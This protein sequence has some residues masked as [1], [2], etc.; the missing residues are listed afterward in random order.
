MQV[1]L[2]E[3][4]CTALR[5]P[6]SLAHL[7]GEQCFLPRRQSLSATKEQQQRQVPLGY[8]PRQNTI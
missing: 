1:I 8:T 4:A 3:Q 5:A 7:R 2:R 6:A